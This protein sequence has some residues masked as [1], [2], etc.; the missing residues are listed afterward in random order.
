VILPRMGLYPWECGLCRRI[1]LLRQRS[2][3]YTS[4]VSWK[5]SEAEL[6]KTAVSSEA[7]TQS[8]APGEK[9]ANGTLGLPVQPSTR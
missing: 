9:Q 1:Y 3:A 8:I 2:G 5:G 6:S 4:S 7:G